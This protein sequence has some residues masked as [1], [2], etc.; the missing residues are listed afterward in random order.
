MYTYNRTMSVAPPR[1]A[2]EHLRDGRTP[3]WDVG[4]L[5]FRA[6]WASPHAALWLWQLSLCTLPCPFPSSPLFPLLP[7][8]PPPLPLSFPCA[9]GHWVKTSPQKSKTLLLNF[10]SYQNC[11]YLYVHCINQI[12]LHVSPYVV[13][14]IEIENK[15]IKLMTS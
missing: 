12:C 4:E 14:S 8:F 7:P 10:Q 6:R 1:A 5:D 13:C 11:N 2:L 9:G 3:V 15:I